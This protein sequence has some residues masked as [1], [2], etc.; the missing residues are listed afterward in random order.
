MA[1]N[2]DHFGVRLRRETLEPPRVTFPAAQRRSHRRSARPKYMP[3]AL[4]VNGRHRR[5]QHEKGHPP[6][7]SNPRPQGSGPC[8]LPTE[9]GGLYSCILS[10]L[11]HRHQGPSLGG[12]PRASK[13]RGVRKRAAPGIEPGTSRTRS[14]NHATRPSSLCSGQTQHMGAS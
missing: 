13:G 9:L 8:A 14:E 4:D 2:I 11:L 10:L 1:H 7:G 6:W 3:L 5:R 12:Y